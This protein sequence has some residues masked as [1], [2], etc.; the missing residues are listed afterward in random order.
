MWRLSE[1]VWLTTRFHPTLFNMKGSQDTI[2]L[3][4]S[5]SCIPCFLSAL[6]ISINHSYV[7]PKSLRFSTSFILLLFCFPPFPYS[8]CFHLIFSSFCHPGRLRGGWVY[9]SDRRKS[10]CWKRKRLGTTWELSFLWR[11]TFPRRETSYYRWYPSDTVERF[12][13]TW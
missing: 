7:F 8:S 2:Q 11:S 9:W 4:L 1:G 12:Y 6:F 13:Y 5:R 10:A 3:I